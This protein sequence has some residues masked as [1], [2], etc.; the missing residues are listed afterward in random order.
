MEREKGEE[1]ER[2]KKEIN[3]TFFFSFFG[4]TRLSELRR[5]ILPK[6]IHKS[7]KSVEKFH[8]LK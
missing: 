7:D 2:K 4:F 1:K 3:V 6:A 8:P 5:Q